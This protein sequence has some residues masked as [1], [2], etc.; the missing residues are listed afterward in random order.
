[1][2]PVAKYC[3][4]D[5]FSIEGQI[6]FFLIE[7][8]RSAGEIYEYVGASQPT[9]SKRIGR[10]LDLGM[11]ELKSS[12]G[13]RRVSIYGVTDSFRSYLAETNMTRVIGE[14]ILHAPKSVD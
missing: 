12:T 6:A 8:E 10:M 11:I 3:E 13:D 5:L 7:C 2:P 4:H 9:I 1:M 14:I